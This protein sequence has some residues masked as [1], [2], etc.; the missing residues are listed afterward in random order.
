MEGLS[1]RAFVPVVAVALW[2]GCAKELS[3]EDRVAQLGRPGS[4]EHAR[5]LVA[6]G[7]DAV[8]ALERGLT[9]GPARARHEAGVALLEIGEPPAVEAVFRAISSGA[10]P[11]SL[12]MSFPRAGKFGLSLC[13]QSLRSVSAEDR[14][15]ALRLMA[16]FPDWTEPIAAKRPGSE[17]LALAAI[18]LAEV[19]ETADATMAREMPA[20][21]SKFGNAGVRRLVGNLNSPRA[22]ARALSARMLAAVKDLSA[23]SPLAQKSNDADPGV[24][25]AVKVALWEMRC[26][27]AER[28]P[29]RSAEAKP[30]R[31]GRRGGPPRVR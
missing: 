19:A 14:S 26:P 18:A 10:A 28:P 20:V 31:Q 25:E 24:R 7:L 2:A 23:C 21:A 15:A 27:G 30:S 17:D 1:A 12:A 3:F 6:A 8:P 16:L 22:E 11:G 9:T 13:V 5:A 4:E 29:G